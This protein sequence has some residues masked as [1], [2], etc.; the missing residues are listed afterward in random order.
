MNNRIKTFGHGSSDKDI[1]EWFTK[2]DNRKVTSI[3]SIPQT[4]TNDL[5]KLESYV[6]IIVFYE[7]SYQNITNIKDNNDLN[8]RG[9]LLKRNIKKEL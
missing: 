8:S 3:R 4:F 9:T 6:K 5:D 2:N 7:E 1:N